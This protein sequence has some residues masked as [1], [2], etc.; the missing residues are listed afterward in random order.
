M[1]GLPNLEEEK[2]FLPSMMQSCIYCV[3]MFLAQTFRGKIFHF[4][5]FIQFFIYL[6]L[7][8]CFLHYKGILAFIPEYY[9]A[10]GYCYCF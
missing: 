4:N 9:F 1:V 7:N 8:T 3:L 6:Y 5:M 10:Y 2:S